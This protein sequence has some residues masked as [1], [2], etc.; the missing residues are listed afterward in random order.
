MFCFLEAENALSS[1]SAD[2]VVV[3]FSVTDSDSLG[4]AEEILQYLWKTGSLNTRATIVVGNKADL[5]RS[6][7]VPIDATL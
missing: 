6:R 7:Q 4:E 1:Y 2:C 5:V 3:V